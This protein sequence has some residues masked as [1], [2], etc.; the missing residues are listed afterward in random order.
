M[1]CL[2]TTLLIDISRSK[3]GRKNRARE[4]IRELVH[5]EEIL[6]TTR[7]NVAELYVGIYKAD[8]SNKEQQ[9]VEKVLSELKLLEFD[10]FA[11]QISG[12]LTSHLQSIGKPAGDMDV[13][14]AATALA[15]NDPIIVTRNP[16]HYANLPG[17]KVET[18]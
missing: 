9:A 18:Y 14:I 7:F 1:A 4:K 6:C 11:A 3:G 12:R 13:L 8:H 10:D 15:N 5:R 17:L 16:I 2:D